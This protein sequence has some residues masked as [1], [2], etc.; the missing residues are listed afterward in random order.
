M[1]N[2][3]SHKPYVLLLII[4]L[5]SMVSAS[6]A[7]ANRM[8]YPRAAGNTHIDKVLTDP[9]E[10]NDSM[11]NAT[12]IAYDDIVWAEIGAH[13]DVEYYED[14]DFF[15]FSGYAGDDLIVEVSASDNLAPWLTLLDAEGNVLDDIWDWPPGSPVQLEHSLPADGEFFLEMQ[16]DCREGGAGCDGPYRLYLRFV[17]PFEP[18]DSMETAVPLD[19]GELIR[20]TI[21]THNDV[22]FYDDLDFFVYESQSEHSISIYIN[23]LGDNLDP[24]CALMDTTGKILVE[25]LRV[26]DFCHIEHT[27]SVS[28]VY[29]I[30]IF[31][32]CGEGGSG[33]QGPYS[34]N[35]DVKRQEIFLPIVIST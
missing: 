35:L 12:L 2:L 10:P 4:I 21:D 31:A 22:P 27:L 15:R 5:I 32:V 24:D 6:A 34:L 29:F 25:D 19:A 8:V 17:D 3:L 11:E 13:D 14:K 23:A 7:G 30:K 1:N 20:A 26:G 28:S 33:C 18:N 9:Y 16:G